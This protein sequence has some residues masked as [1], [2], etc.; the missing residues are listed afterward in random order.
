M[1]RTKNRPDVSVIMAVYNLSDKQILGESI[2][3][4]LNQTFQNL[5]LIICDDASTDGTWEAL[6]EIAATDD[7]IRLL[8]NRENRKAG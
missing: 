4:V 6:K 3:S 8:R 2:R 5:E 7:R 1:K